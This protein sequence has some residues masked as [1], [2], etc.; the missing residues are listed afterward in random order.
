[1]GNSYMSVL[2][3]KQAEK[4]GDRVALKYRDYAV[5]KWLPVT[6]RQFS[7]QVEKVADS[8]VALA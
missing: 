8:L 7:E 2:I 1:M 5:G 6:W 3:K 4:Y